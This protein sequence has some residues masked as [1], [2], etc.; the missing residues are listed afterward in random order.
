MKSHVSNNN[1]LIMIQ[2]S[3]ILFDKKVCNEHG[4]IRN[5][6]D[7]AKVLDNYNEY[8]ILNGYLKI[9]MKDN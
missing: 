7:M 6:W 4:V 8:Y 9:L 1:E 5:M 2:V 3:H